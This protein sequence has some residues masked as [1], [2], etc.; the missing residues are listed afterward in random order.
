MTDEDA[1]FRKI[2][3]VS[4][5]MPGDILASDILYKSG[6]RPAARSAGRNLTPEIIE[7]LQRNRDIVPSGIVVERRLADIGPDDINAETFPRIVQKA[8]HA[9]S[10][11][12]GHVFDMVDD[13]FDRSE[14]DLYEAA[15]DGADAELR[16]KNDGRYAE[17]QECVASILHRS[18]DDV[19][20]LLGAI[21]KEHAPL[22]FVTDKLFTNH[23]LR[24][25]SAAVGI[26]SF[27]IGKLYG[28]FIGNEYELHE[29]VDANYLKSLMVSGALHCIGDAA[30]EH[31][32][33]PKKRAE[34][35]RMKHFLT[36]KMLFDPETE[37]PINGILKKEAADA[38]LCH[39]RYDGRADQ[40]SPNPHVYVNSF[41]YAGNEYRHGGH[42]RTNYM[43]YAADYRREHNIQNRI[44]IRP[45]S[46]GSS[47]VRLADL[48]VAKPKIELLDELGADP[49]N[50]NFDVLSAFA[51]S[52]GFD[53]DGMVVRLNF[54]EG[55]RE[56]DNLDGYSAVVMKTGERP[57]F[58]VFANRADERLDEY[59]TGTPKERDNKLRGVDNSRYG[60]VHASRLGDR[61]IKRLTRDEMAS[62]GLEKYER[63]LINPWIYRR[64]D[65][66]LKAIREQ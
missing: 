37:E 49:E 6:H 54:R 57:Y 10:G 31:I 46:V 40:A 13:F 23:E 24:Y 59:I 56:E 8:H 61:C 35:A 16:I 5:L 28:N 32:K 9:L 30:V 62:R 11:N 66:A 14:E 7:Q 4:G 55:T 15:R 1:R 52:T 42:F 27:L 19:M 38:F 34:M 45:I 53:T 39:F 65:N 17:F 18:Y 25:H 58:V 51:T 33:D 47:I 41:M 44:E 29:E 36:Y 26:F 60:G 3:G 2:V 48:F 43:D 50:I 21:K 22:W 64:M 12:L 63:L 20:P